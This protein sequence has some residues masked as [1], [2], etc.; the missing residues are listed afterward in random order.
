MKSLHA[1]VLGALC[2]LRD[3]RAVP[4]AAP[5]NTS[6]PSVTISTAVAS[7]TVPLTNTVPSQQPLPPVQAWCPSKIFCAGEVRSH[8]V[9]FRS[10]ILMYALYS[11]SYCKP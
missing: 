10:L 11:H 3:V 1:S 9:T 8:L 5:I 6:V 7:P 4:Q 2:L